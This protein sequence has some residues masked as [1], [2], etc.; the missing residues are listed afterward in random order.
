VKKIILCAALFVQAFFLTAQ[1]V[2]PGYRG[3]WPDTNK[4]ITVLDFM[5][6]TGNGAINLVYHSGDLPFLRNEIY[7][8]YGRPFVNK[9]YQDYFNARRWY[10]IREDFSESWLSPSDR[11]NA[12]FIRSL[13][14]APGPDETTRL[15][16]KNIEY[17]GK[18][19]VLTFTSREKLIWTDPGVDF[20][21]YGLSG[22]NA[23]AMDWQ[24]VGDW[25]IMYN[26]SSYY[27]YFEMVAYKL[28][29]ASRRI[30]DSVQGRVEKYEK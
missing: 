16:L 6:Q 28:D 29:H 10:K 18:K 14:Q 4:K 13:E 23:L 8:R 9:A 25:V 7:A 3:F 26:E 30:T 19:A 12:E 2:L 11:A 24:A 27:G 1:N 17:R 22:Y 21:A 5:G 20:G 15:V